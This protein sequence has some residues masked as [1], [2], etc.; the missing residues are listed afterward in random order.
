MDVNSICI[1][2]VIV[3]GFERSR[4]HP[5]ITIVKSLP[6]LSVVQS[7]YG[8]YRISVENK[9]TAE[10]GEGG[11][12]IAPANATQ[13]INEL[14]GPDGTMT[15]QWVFFDVE[16][17]KKHRLEELFSFPLLLPANHNERIAELIARAKE[18]EDLPSRMPYLSEVV[19][20]L[21]SVAGPTEVKNDLAARLQNYMEN[22]YAGEVSA[23]DLCKMMCCSRSAMYARF[24]D[25]LGDTPV[26]YLNNIRIRHSQELLLDTDTPIA[27]IASKVGIRDQFYFARLFRS[28]TGTSAS[29]YRKL[30]RRRSTD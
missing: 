25:L 19:E 2:N 27:E 16:I 6:T 20:I 1:S 18:K 3:G 26:R 22:N 29:E 21:L 24:R 12:F 10:T 15:A 14:P 11:V 8:S 28:I 17:N 9:G 23:A 7:V 13:Q 30:G 4:V 5:E